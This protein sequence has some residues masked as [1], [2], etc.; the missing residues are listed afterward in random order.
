MS[1]V[2]LLL[3]LLLAVLTLVL[4]VTLLIRSHSRL[5]EVPDTPSSREGFA[6][7]STVSPPTVSPL[8]SPATIFVSIPSYRDT[9][10][11]KTLHSLFANADHPDRIFVGL[12]EQ[13]HPDHP[14][15]NCTLAAATPLAA[16]ESHIRRVRVP[17]TKAKGPLWARTQITR[18]YRG[19]TYVMMID[20]HSVFLR[21]WDTRMKSELDYLRDHYRVDKP[22]LSCYPHHSKTLQQHDTD[23]TTQPTPINEKR[24][25]TAHICNVTKVEQLPL[26]LGAEEKPSGKYYRTLFIG[27]GFVFSYGAFCDTLG[28]ALQSLHLPHVFSG[29]EI[30][31]AAIAYTHG[32]N[33]YSPPYVNVFHLYEHGKPSWFTDNVAP[34]K[35]ATNAQRA[36]EARLR[37]LLDTDHNTG[38][39][40][41]ARTLGDFWNEMGFNRGHARTDP[42]S[43]AEKTD[44]DAVREAYPPESKDRWCARA[45]SWEYPV[46]ELFR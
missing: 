16:Y 22:V 11:S 33:V 9:D 35:R 7:S 25:L 43:D 37:T 42:S 38:C 4:A 41:T 2:H 40:G 36:S 12:Y 20:A 30:L 45:E 46:V 27:A 23:T 5:H 28:T 10:C 31:L 19:E 39:L 13:N 32:W 14:D 44:A 15:E 6:T 8:T 29:E 26:V 3:L 24:D 1:T 21:H 18:L 17:H 34:R